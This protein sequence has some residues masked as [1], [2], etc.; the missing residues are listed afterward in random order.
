MTKANYSR[1]I[2]AAVFLA[3]FASTALGYSKTGSMTLD[4]NSYSS[5]VGGEFTAIS[6]TL[7]PTQLGYSTE[8]Q[9]KIGSQTGFGTFCLEYQEKF[10]PGTTYSYSISNTIINNPKE[11][12][13]IGV[14]WLY[15]E[16]ATGVLNGYNY[17]N[18]AD[19]LE[20]AGELQDTIWWLEGQDYSNGK[21]PE[22]TNIF[23]TDVLNKFG[24]VLKAEAD[25]DGVY[26]V[27]I[28]N[29][30]APPGYD[31]QA[32]LILNP[33]PVPEGGTSIMLLGMA[34]GGLAVVRRKLPA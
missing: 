24:T 26:D 32:Q 11:V 12:L 21:S 30:G 8:A 17:T 25:N 27:A 16:F 34:L 13:T 7:N 22:P 15:E 19:R 1:G 14:A 3:A 33:T 10:T 2:A 6:T 28:L 18:T 4:Q 31:N 20:D 23:T 9:V 5:G 29:M